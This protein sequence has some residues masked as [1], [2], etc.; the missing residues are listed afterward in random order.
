MAYSI[1]G[2]SDFI[3][4]IAKGKVAGHSLIVIRGHNPSQTSASGFVDMSE[5][6]DITYLTT[7]ETMNI[8]S[9]DVDDDGDPVDTGLRT[10]LIQGVDNT[11]AAIQEV[12]LLNGTTNVLHLKS[13]LRVNTM[14]GLTAGSSGWNEGVITAKASSAATTQCEMDAT[15]GISMDSHYTIPLNH[16]GYVYQVEFNAARLVGGTAPVIEFIGLARSG[17]DGNSWIQLFDKRMDTALDDEIDV[18]LPFPAPAIARTD[19]RLRTDTDQNS[20]ET[21]SR[22]YIMLVDNTV[23]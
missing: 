3:L 12:I 9:T 16:T 5:F 8:V 15:E 20:T 11:G 7:A 2:R 1:T 13:Y 22:M 10:M 14:V 19:I 6:G 23:T 17:G 21:R 4:D 18:F